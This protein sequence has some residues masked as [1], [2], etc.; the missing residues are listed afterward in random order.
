MSMCRKCRLIT[1]NPLAKSKFFDFAEF[2]DAGPEAVLLSVR[3]YIHL[4]ARLISHPL[5]G[6]ILPGVSPYKSVVLTKT[7]SDRLDVPDVF[8]LE[9]IEYTIDKL[10]KILTGFHGYDE[11]TLEDFMVVDLDMIE[12][13][14]LSNIF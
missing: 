7:P 2:V 12:K 4:G 11:K 10:Q 3:D 14:F 6:G 5:S 8:S 1:N 13:C 9:L